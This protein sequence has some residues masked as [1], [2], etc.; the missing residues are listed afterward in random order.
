MLKVNTGAA[1]LGLG[2]IIGLKY[3]F[4]I[5]LGSLAVWW[6]IV[7]GMAILFP[8][9]I[10]NQWDPNITTAVGD[11]SAEQIFTS[12]GK[13][14]GIGGIAMAGV[15]GIIKSWG[16]IKSAVGLAAKEMRGGSSASR[17]Q[18]RTQRDLSFKIIAIG[19]VVT[20]L[21]TL[22]FFYFGVMDGNIIHAL[23]AIVLVAVIAFLFTT[24]AANAIAIVVDRALPAG[25]GLV[26]LALAHDNLDA[27]VAHVERL[28]GPL[29]A[30]TEHR[31]G[32]ALEH[33]LRLLERKLL[34]GRDFF[35]HLAEFDLHDVPS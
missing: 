2:Y 3:A 6:L 15:I 8:T 7:P 16:I 18:L 17:D 35:C 28:S 23:V 27:I 29:D 1:V 31:H 21:L 22:A 12:Y 9:D 5:C 25:I 34:A 19:S 26:A 32:L 20:I 11:M 24:V 13:S 10:L 33:L 4:I 30:V 14:I